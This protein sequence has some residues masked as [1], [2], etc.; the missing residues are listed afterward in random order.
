MVVKATVVG[1]S[2]Y[3]YQARLWY[4]LT[5]CKDGSKYMLLKREPDNPYDRNAIKVVLCGEMYGKLGYIARRECKD[6]LPILS[7]AT[8]VECD[9]DPEEVIRGTKDGTLKA[10]PIS[11]YCREPEHIVYTYYNKQMDPLYT[12]KTTYFKRRNVQ[13]AEDDAWWNEAEVVGLRKFDT[14]VD[15]N[16]AE[17]FYITTQKPKYNK[18]CKNGTFEAITYEDDVEEEIHEKSEFPVEE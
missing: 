8:S 14:T 12:G 11:I 13:H 16:I 17:I 6:I 9:M 10:I 3:E 7:Y 15:M 4:W 1:V 2:I 5:S 18:S